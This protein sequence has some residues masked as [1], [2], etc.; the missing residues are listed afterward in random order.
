MA[1]PTFCCAPP[2]AVFTFPTVSS[3][4]PSV[5]NLSLPVTSPTA[6]LTLP[7]AWSIFPSRSFL[8]HMTCSHRCWHTDVRGN[9]MQQTAC[10]RLCTSEHLQRLRRSRRRDGTESL[11][12]D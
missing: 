6:C 4:L 8:F 1:A 10:E 3:T 9:S 7:L 11:S 5:F 2:T 12:T